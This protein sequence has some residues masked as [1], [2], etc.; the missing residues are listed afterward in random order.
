VNR[1]RCWLVVLALVAGCGGK[2]PAPP[3]KATPTATAMPVH[4]RES[5]PRRRFALAHAAVA[6]R[7]AASRR[8]AIP[9]LMYHVVSAAPRH[10][11]YPQL[12]VAPGRFA[13]EMTA[14][15]DAGYHAITLSEA[16]AAWRSGGPLPAKPIVLSFDDGY[17][18]DYTHA[19][20]VLRRLR[21]PGVLN[22]ALENVGRDGITAREVRG[23]IASGWEVDSHTLTHPDLT[24]LS[25]AALRR[26][27]TSS[28][29]QIQARFGVPAR[30]FCYPSGRFDARVLAAVKAAGYEAATTEVAG[31]GAGRELLTLKRVR[32]SDVDTPASL[33]RRLGK[34]STSQGP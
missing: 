34:G 15:G 11:P 21:W 8:A 33:L 28:R 3:P 32:V 14:L 13:R 5:T 16:V 23:L 29:R 25:D 24:T 17:A 22:L 19:R 2:A 7:G 6:T 20:P 1:S 30:F 27:L 31:F 12:W 9:I 26:E 10:A 4:H 18:A